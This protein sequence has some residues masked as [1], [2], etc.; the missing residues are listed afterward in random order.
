MLM[1][2][3]LLLVQSPKRD[4][5]RLMKLGPLGRKAKPKMK[6]ADA[7]DAGLVGV[8]SPKW[9]QLMLMMLG[10]LGRKA[11]NGTS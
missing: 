11:L 10:L 6:P 1:M 2:L 7:H 5:L 3:G 8:Q 4:Q 9:N